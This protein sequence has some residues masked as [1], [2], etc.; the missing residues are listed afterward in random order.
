MTAPLQ[1]TITSFPS[2]GVAV[3]STPIAEQQGLPSERGTDRLGQ[4]NL[5]RSGAQFHGAVRHAGELIAVGVVDV[6]PRCLS[7]AYLFWDPD[8]ASLG[9]GKLTALKEIAWVQAASARSPALQWYH[10]VSLVGTHSCREPVP[11]LCA[12]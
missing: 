9:L 4:G 12:H 7:S 8:W 1:D 6:L 5:M 11:T 3:L 10:M 2:P